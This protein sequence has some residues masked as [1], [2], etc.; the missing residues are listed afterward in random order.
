MINLPMKLA[1]TLCMSINMAV[2]L[3][4]VRGGGFALETTK[5][6][7]SLIFTK[8]PGFSPPAPLSVVNPLGLA[9]K[10]LTRTTQESLGSPPGHFERQLTGRARVSG[11]VEGH[12]VWVDR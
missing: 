5:L 2:Q 3:S 10:W 1:S 12:Q 9:H 6:P 8:H 4:E 11:R 7:P